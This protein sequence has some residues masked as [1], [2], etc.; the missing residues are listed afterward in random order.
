MVV[1]ALASALYFLSPAFD[2][3]LPNNI[4][5][6]YCSHNKHR[7]WMFGVPLTHVNEFSPA[8]PLYSFTIVGPVT[9]LPCRRHGFRHVLQD[10]W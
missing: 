7:T 5:E 3:H 10:P 2:H 8:T 6:N 1:T 4:C 9:F